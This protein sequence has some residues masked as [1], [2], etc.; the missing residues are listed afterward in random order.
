MNLNHLRYAVEV[1]R[2]RSISKAAEALYMGQPNLSRA[3]RELEESLGVP[4]F[5][6]TPKGITP[7]PQGEEFLER[8][9]HILDEVD[10]MEGLFRR[11]ETQEQALSLVL[12]RAGYLAEAVAA[13]CGM[14]TLPVLSCRETNPLHAV[15]LVAEEE[16]RVGIVHM[17]PAHTRYFDALLA[18]KGLTSHELGRLPVVALMGSHHPAADREEAAP[19][20]M[21]D[22]IEVA[23]GDP[24]APCLPPSEAKKSTWPSGVGRRLWV[25][26]RATQFD[27]LTAV[28]GAYS[29]TVPLPNGQLNRFGLV[30]RPCSGHPAVRELLVLRKHVRL[31]AREEDLLHFFAE[32]QQRLV[33]N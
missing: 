2:T 19:A 29:W 15:A 6:R 5:K 26:D 28:P 11:E 31:T 4:L 12:P 20:S 23:F 17:D 32:A 27:L 30:Q 24:Y 10:A 13:F 14:G 16:Y 7:T 18:D 9:R 33:N 25:Y 8:A 1:G 3:I 21:G 22:G